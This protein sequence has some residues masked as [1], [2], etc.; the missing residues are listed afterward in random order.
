MAQNLLQ[1]FSVYSL[2]LQNF[3]ISYRNAQNLLQSY[4]VYD[5][6]FM[7]SILMNFKEIPTC[8]PVQEQM[9]PEIKPFTLDYVTTEHTTFITIQGDRFLNRSVPI[10]STV[11]MTCYYEGNGR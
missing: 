8:P 1:V 5:F 9:D 3:I 11:N 2:L 7:A 4:L 6:D 10:R